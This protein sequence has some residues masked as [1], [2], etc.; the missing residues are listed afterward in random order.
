MAKRTVR[1]PLD[2]SRQE[3]ARQHAQQERHEHEE[4]RRPC[5]EDA[6]GLEPQQDL[7]THEGSDDEDLRV[8]EVDEL[9]DAVHHGVPEGD[10]GVHEAEGDAVEQ[11]LR[12]DAEQDFEVHRRSVP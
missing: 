9:E 1:H 7:D 6:V 4:K 5:L 3:P 12:E 10:Q 8:G 2:T 11:D